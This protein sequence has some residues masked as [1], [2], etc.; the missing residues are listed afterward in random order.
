MAEGD[1]ILRNEA[2]IGHRHSVAAGKQQRP[3]MMP[4][5]AERFDETFPGGVAPA[6]SPINGRR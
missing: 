3:A 5:V 2:G 4:G 6:A 1:F